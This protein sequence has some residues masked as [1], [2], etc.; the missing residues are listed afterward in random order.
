VP[1]AVRR[2]I[3]RPFSLVMQRRVAPP[4]PLPS[5]PAPR[6]R[7]APTP[8]ACAAPATTPRIA[9]QGQS[10]GCA[11]GPVFELPRIPASLSDAVQPSPGRP[12]PCPLAS[13]PMRLAAS[14][15]LAGDGGRGC[16]RLTPFRR[17]RLTG[18]EAGLSVSPMTRWQ[19]APLRESSGSGWWFSVSLPTGRLPVLPAVRSP[20]LPGSLSAGIAFG[21]AYGL[22]RIL[23]SAGCA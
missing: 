23:R 2:I 4:L 19:V 20:G 14:S 7:V 15:G 3:D 10:M 21:G 1:C 5:G 16:P 8:R 22:P 13:P 18:F 11:G 6:I 17:C 9:P 12:V